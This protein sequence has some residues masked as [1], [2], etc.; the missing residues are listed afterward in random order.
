MIIREMQIKV[1]QVLIRMFSKETLVQLSGAI[2]QLVQPFWTTVRQW[3]KLSIEKKK[4]K[5][6]HLYDHHSQSEYR[7]NRCMCIAQRHASC[8]IIHN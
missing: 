4:K 8:T 3:T 1:V 5:K 7:P 2:P 6:K